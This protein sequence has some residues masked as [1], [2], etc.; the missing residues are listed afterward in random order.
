MSKLDTFQSL[1]LEVSKPFKK[2]TSGLHGFG[3]L[4]SVPMA[5]IDPPNWGDGSPVMTK[6]DKHIHAVPLPNLEKCVVICTLWIPIIQV[7]TFHVMADHQHWS[8]GWSVLP[9]HTAATQSIGWT[10]PNVP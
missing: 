5:C 4:H 6:V 3:Y 2:S 1:K 7:A 10:L 9:L 8:V